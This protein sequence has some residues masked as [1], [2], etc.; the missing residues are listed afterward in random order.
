MK[1]YILNIEE[2]S[3]HMAQIYSIMYD[4]DDQTLLDHFFEE[5]AKEHEKELEEIAIR[6]KVMGQDTGCKLNF[7]RAHEG[8]PGDGVAALSF[9]RFRR[10]QTGKYQGLSR[11]CPVKR[12][13]TRN[14]I[15]CRVYKQGN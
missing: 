2:F 15:A 12:K 11:R 5:N 14:E 10:I 6:L 1:F 3:G 4:G 9:H 7:F 8:A 13:G